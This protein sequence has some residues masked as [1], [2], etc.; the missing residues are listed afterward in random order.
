MRY[1]ETEKEL[2]IIVKTLKEFRDI[3]LGEQLK[4]YTDHKKLTFF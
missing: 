3:L 1:M 2:L 4:L